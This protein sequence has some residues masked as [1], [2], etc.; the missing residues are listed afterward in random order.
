MHGPGYSGSGTPFVHRH[1][2]PGAD[3]SADF[4]RYAVEWDADE[5]RF[6]VD[7]DLHYLVT[8]DQVLARGAWVFDQPFYIILNLAVGGG[9]DGDPASDAILPATM[10]V[11][12]VRVYER[13][14]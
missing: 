2:P 7:D 10:L 1:A 5:A 4:H 11:D 13:A 6:F 12:Y 9:F 3:F 14:R 8:R